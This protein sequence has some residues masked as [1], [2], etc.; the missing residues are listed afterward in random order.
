MKRTEAESL[1]G[2]QVR[3]WTAMNGDYTGVL[4]SVHGS[5][6]RG[7]VRITG[8]LKVAQHLERGAPCR[9]GFRVGETIEVGGS[10]ISA[11]TGSEQGRQ[12]VETDYLAALLKE[13]A[14][15]EERV[16]PLQGSRNAWL[17]PALVAALGVVIEAERRRLQ[18]QPWCLHD[19]G[20]GAD[21]QRS[22][23]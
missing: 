22:Q 18:G 12:G 13:R 2:S 1:I 17:A 7:V 10:S 6:W 14:H 9:R 11:W 16:E 19:D 15:W 5:P 23:R 21:H 4:E 3:A 20:R 8:I